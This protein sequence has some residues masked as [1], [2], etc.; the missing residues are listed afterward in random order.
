MKLMWMGSGRWQEGWGL[1]AETYIVIDADTPTQWFAQAATDGHARLRARSPAV[2]QPCASRKRLHDC[3]KF[4]WR[5][6]EIESNAALPGD[7]EQ[8]AGK[9]FKKKKKKRSFGLHNLTQINEEYEK[10]MV[11]EDKCLLTRS[12]AR[13]SRSQ[14]EESAVGVLWIFSRLDQ[15][16]M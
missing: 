11:T 12:V 6:P 7:A 1:W 13:L 3:P 14:Q 8:H 10:R 4:A 16:E 9:L 2:I 5:G 15:Q